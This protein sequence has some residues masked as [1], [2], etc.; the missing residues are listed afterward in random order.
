MPLSIIIVVGLY[1]LLIAIIE[2]KNKKIPSILPTAVILI[3]SIGVVLKNPI[4][5]VYGLLGFVFAWLLYEFYYLKSV[6][7]IKVIIIISLI[8]DS[9]TKFM[10]FMLLVGVLGFFYTLILKKHKEI[11]F[12]PLLFI[13]YVILILMIYLRNVF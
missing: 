9:M 13:I 12:T 1:L 2:T 3:L 11:P 8:L 6:A 7:D 5:M 10:V 4:T